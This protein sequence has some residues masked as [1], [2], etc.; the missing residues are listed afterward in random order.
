MRGGE[1]RRVLLDLKL[2]FYSAIDHVS[3]DL[4]SVYSPR[5]GEAMKSVKL[6]E[7]ESMRSCT[8]LLRL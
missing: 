3:A 7:T 1:L 6:A 2:T 5:Y 4:G 8:Q